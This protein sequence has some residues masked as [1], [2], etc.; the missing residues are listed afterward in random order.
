MEDKGLSESLKLEFE[1]IKDDFSR[2]GEASSNIKK[3]LRQIGIDAQII[4]RV[5]IA[6]YEAEINIVIHSE[7]GKITLYIYP[8]FIKIIAKDRGP[9][10]ES[11]ELAMKEGYSTASNKVRELGFGAGLGLPNMK[12]CSDKFSIESERGKSTIVTMIINMNEGGDEHD[13]R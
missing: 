8:E 5:A 3:V 2:A 7:G 4:R 9:G 12:R 1:V 10:I 11:I 6:T 13:N